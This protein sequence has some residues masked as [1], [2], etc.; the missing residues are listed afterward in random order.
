MLDLIFNNA[1]KN[2]ESVDFSKLKNKRVLLTGCTGLIGIN[3]LATLKMLNEKHNY[4]IEIF[5]FTHRSPEQ[6][7]DPL[8][9]GCFLLNGDLTKSDS[10]DILGNIFAENQWGVDCIIHTAGYAQPKKFTEDKFSTIFL[11]TQTIYNLFKL[12]NP[13]GSFLFLSSSEIYNGVDIENIEEN[14]IGTTT[15]DHPRSCYIESKRCGEAIIHAFREKGYDAKIAR[16]SLTHGPGTKKNDCRVMSDFVTKCLIDGKLNLI[17]DGQS[18]RTYCYVSDTT[19]MLWNILLHGKDVVYNVSGMSKISILDMAKIIA[20]KLNCEVIIPKNNE[21]ELKG[22][23]KIVNISSKKYIDE[24]GK[25][26]FVPIDDG[27]EKV[28]E[29]IKNI[30]LGGN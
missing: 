11:N 8:F 24:F 23:P 15:P 6:L 26:E 7:F 20:K 9:K 2:I 1:E 30:I 25:K 10:I 5:C 14:F 13:G 17:D 22:N 18:I 12:L 4:D 28:I 29:W 16:V 21:S 3:L 19:E 27:I